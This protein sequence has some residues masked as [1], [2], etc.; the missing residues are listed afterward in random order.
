MTSTYN[1]AGYCS[2]FMDEKSD[3][4]NLIEKQKDTIR[5]LVEQKFPGSSLTLFEDCDRGGDTFQKREGFQAMRQG[6]I[7]NEYDILV[8]TDFSRFSH[9]NSRGLIELEDL[10]DHGVRIIS[11]NDDIDY[12][13]AD[14]WLKIQLRFLIGESP[15]K[16][17]S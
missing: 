8:V 10:R 1:I 13:N 11:I 9:P 4:N 16:N 12:P 14:D 5:E 15:I 6:L 17:A 2:V 7:S 3:L